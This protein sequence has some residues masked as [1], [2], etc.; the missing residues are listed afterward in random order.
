MVQLP[1]RPTRLQRFAAT[2]VGGLRAHFAGGWAR[3]SLRLL[4]LLGGFYAGGNLTAYVLPRFPGGR[5]AL[6]LALVVVLELVVRLRTRVLPPL[7]DSRPAP[8]L[9]MIAD[10]LRLG[11]VYAVVLEAFKLGT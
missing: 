10:N 5:P 7:P 11:L 4:A 2:V 3:T 1:R 8:F 6:V 9:W